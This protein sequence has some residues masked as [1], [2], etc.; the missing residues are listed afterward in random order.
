MNRSNNDRF[1][2]RQAELEKEFESLSTLADERRHQLEN[3]VYLYQ[4]LRESQD[5]EA[6]INEQLL[7]AM[8]EDYG[9][10]YEHLKASSMFCMKFFYFRNSNLAFS[11]QNS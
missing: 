1:V 11:G 10:D 7:I 2:A 4:Y 3:A 8:S 9:I 6:W 5:L